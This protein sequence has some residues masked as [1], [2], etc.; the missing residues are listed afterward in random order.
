MSS[1]IYWAHR[2]GIDQGEIGYIKFIERAAHSILSQKYDR[3]LKGLTNHRIINDLPYINQ[4][5]NLNSLYY[6]PQKGQLTDIPNIVLSQ[7]KERIAALIGNGLSITRHDAAGSGTRLGLGSKYFLTPKQ[8]VKA[9]YRS[10]NPEVIA[11][12]DALREKLKSECDLKGDPFN[13]ILPISF[14]NR[15]MLQHAINTK[16]IAES[17]GQDPKRL[18][19]SAINFV[20][21][22]QKSAFDIIDEFQENNF[23]GFSPDNTLFFI[24]KTHH[25]F[26]LS[27][28]GDFR[29]DTKTPQHLYDHGAI[30][31]ESI[32][33]DQIFKI[34]N[35]GGRFNFLKRSEYFDILKKTE[36]MV[37]Y[38]IADS[39]FIYSPP[40]YQG[41]SAALRLGEEKAYRMIMEVVGQKKDYP[42][43][44]GFL[45]EDRN[46][47]RT[48]MLESG[49]NGISIHDGDASIKFLRAIKFL[50]RNV[51]HLI[52][53]YEAIDALIK[54]SIPI[55]LTAID[56]HL[57]PQLK[58]GAK[59][60]ILPTGFVKRVNMTPIQSLKTI[61]DIPETLGS[62]IRQDRQR[63][64]E[65]FVQA[66]L[67]R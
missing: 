12:M 23:F 65:E 26:S 20:V 4:Y 60:F 54:D 28:D 38:N 56:G 1:A 9:A 3:G 29:Y 57:Y 59:N 44:G 61:S 51:N 35:N 50:N 14:G 46:L 66:V 10:K 48:V 16:S 25:G 30:D 11:E 6:E 36:H 2:H 58:Q 21:I 32:V 45:A 15:H 22:G 42:Q 53:P 18:I 67:V 55:Q 37:S 63:G 47:D 8:L 41:F 43:E 27:K 39:H 24:Q 7:E 17:S 13:N 62:M 33:G 49:Q 5:P 34:G 40:D 31:L 19:K 64:F 52:H